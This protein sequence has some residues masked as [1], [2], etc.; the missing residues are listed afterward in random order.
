MMVTEKPTPL[1]NPVAIVEVTEEDIVNGLISRNRDHEA[2]YSPIGLACQRAFIRQKAVIRLI[3]HEDMQ[4]I[5]TWWRLHVDTDQGSFQWNVPKEIVTKI[6]LFNKTG[7]MQ[8]FVF[9]IFL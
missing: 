5:G 7:A 6:E 3:G 9:C 2:S 1:G 8:P 4:S